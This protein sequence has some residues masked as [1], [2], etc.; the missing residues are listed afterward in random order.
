MFSCCIADEEAKT[1]LNFMQAIS[2]Y[3]VM[4][5]LFNL[6]GGEIL[7]IVSLALILFGAKRLPGFGRGIRNSITEFRRVTR[8]VSEE[9]QDSSFEAGQS[10]GGIY[11]KRAI[12]ALAPDNQV[13]ELYDPEVFRRGGKAQG[14]RMIWYWIRRRVSASVK[15]LMHKLRQDKRG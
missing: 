6:G 5:A 3:G 9:M 8:D 1:K 14:F 7:L 12:E 2:I 10:I 4:M 15:W 13:A 11:G